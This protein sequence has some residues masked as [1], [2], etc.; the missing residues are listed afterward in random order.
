MKLFNMDQYIIQK[1][2]EESRLDALLDLIKKINTLIP[3]IDNRE[4]FTSQLWKL[5]DRY[6]DKV[7]DFS[8]GDKNT[9]FLGALGALLLSWSMTTSKAKIC[10][11]NRQNLD[12]QNG[13]KVPFTINMRRQ[14]LYIIES[15]GKKFLEELGESVFKIAP[16]CND[17]NI[18]EPRCK[19]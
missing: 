7:N 14:M 18:D 5:V 3:S 15:E 9:A 8:Y 6:R 1:G 16:M 2:N 11:A 19:C 10:D 13:G 4:L 17:R 12:I